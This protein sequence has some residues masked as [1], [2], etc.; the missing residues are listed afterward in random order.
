MRDPGSVGFVLR[1]RSKHSLECPSSTKKDGIEL[2]F[3]KTNAFFSSRAL[4]RFALE[5]GEAPGLPEGTTASEK[6]GRLFSKTCRLTEPTDFDRVCART[7]TADRC[8]TKPTSSRNSFFRIA[9]FPPGNAS[10]ALACR[11]ST[12]AAIRSESSSSTRGRAT[13]II[14]SARIRDA[15]S[16]PAW[17]PRTIRLEHVNAFKISALRG[18]RRTA[19]HFH[20]NSAK[21]LEDVAKHYAL[22]FQVV[23]GGAIDLSAQDLADMVASMKLL[24]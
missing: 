19:P 15:R 21:S 9:P 23:T 7:V 14:S 3:Q 17:W 5:R 12:K 24:D 1:F 2:A 6:R 20:H 18:I 13:K 22:F 11:N 8:A 4:R 10:S 16:S